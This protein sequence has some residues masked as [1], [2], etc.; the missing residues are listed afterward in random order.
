MWWIVLASLALAGGEAV[1]SRRVDGFVPAAGYIEARIVGK[2]PGLF[3]TDG[4]KSFL[5]FV[6]SAFPA[7]F[8]R[9]LL[10]KLAE[11]VTEAVT[12]ARAGQRM[13]FDPAIK[14][15]VSSQAAGYCTMIA[16]TEPSPIDGQ[17]MV[18]L[19]FVHNRAC[20]G[21]AG[22]N[23]DAAGLIATPDVMDQ[24]VGSLRWAAT[25]P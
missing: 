10:T 22:C 5:C 23:T 13:Q 20:F 16:A 19:T 2:Q 9:G 8:S 17:L 1:Q 11:G 12:A 15:I 7:N 14:T 3:V 21:S 4:D 25:K 6:G 24:L 18:M